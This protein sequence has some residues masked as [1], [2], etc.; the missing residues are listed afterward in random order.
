MG[1]R[2]WV[3][4]SSF[5]GLETAMVI[6]IVSNGKSS[7]PGKLADAE[8]HFTDGDL[9]GLRLIGFAVWEKR[10]GPGRNVTFPARPYTVNG[11]RRSFALLRPNSD[12]KSQD[13]LRDLVLQAYT[14]FEAQAAIAS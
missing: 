2:M 6:K 3:E 12:P 13:R 9:E 1:K 5:T 4:P 11:E 7:P 14:E 8:L 10:N